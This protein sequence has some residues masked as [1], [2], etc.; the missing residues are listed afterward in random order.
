M[1]WLIGLTRTGKNNGSNILVVIVVMI[2]VHIAITNFQMKNNPITKEDGMEECYTCKCG[3]QAWTIYT[4]EMECGRCRKRISIV[5]LI[6]SPKDFN[7][8]MNED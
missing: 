5:W 6:S 2:G 7:R 3:G 8:D 1:K 4:R